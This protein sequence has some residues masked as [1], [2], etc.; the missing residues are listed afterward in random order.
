MAYDIRIK[1]YYD[2]RIAYMIAEKPIRAIKSEKA[3]KDK[4]DRENS[5]EDDL[6]RSLRRTKQAAYDIVHNNKWDYFITITFNGQVVDRYNYEAV[7]KKLSQTLNNIKKR[8][9]PD[10]QYIVVPELHQ[11]GAIHFHGL[12]NNCAELEIYDS[13]KKDTEK[14]KIYKTAEFEKLGFTD[15]S[16]IRDSSK[17]GTYILKYMT[18]TMGYILD[19]KKYWASRGLNQL[20]E[21]KILVGDLEQKKELIQDLFAS[22]AVVSHCAKEIKT[23]EYTNSYTYIV[24]QPSVQG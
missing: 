17:A 11:D 2:G 9:C 21:S 4:Q 7:A 14:R 22:G 10:M 20:Q 12:V 19:G 16:K 15:L 1:T 18:K 3:I 23:D 5:L 8:K 24:T 6:E 13:G